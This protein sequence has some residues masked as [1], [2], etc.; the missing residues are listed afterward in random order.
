M[1]VGHSFGHC[2]MCLGDDAKDSYI[3]EHEPTTLPNDKK[4]QWCVDDSATE[5]VFIP[6]GERN[7][8]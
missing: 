8:G 5:R 7:K 2:Y 4:R 6:D 3:P 1:G